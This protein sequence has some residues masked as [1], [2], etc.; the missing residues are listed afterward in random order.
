MRTIYLLMVVSVF[1][2]AGSVGFP[3]DAEAQTETLRLTGLNE[4]VE[5]IKDRWGIAHIYAKTETDLFFAQGFNAARDRLFQFELWR[6]K[7]T[8]TTAEI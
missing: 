2:G 1:G 8:G 6:R 7:A 4:P 5:I 3:G